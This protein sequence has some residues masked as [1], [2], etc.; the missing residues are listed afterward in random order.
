M[1]RRRGCSD[2]VGHAATSWRSSGGKC[3][4][5]GRPCSERAGLRDSFAKL[6]PRGFHG[7]AP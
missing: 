7:P 6:E 5:D 1:L 2:A 4:L 3:P